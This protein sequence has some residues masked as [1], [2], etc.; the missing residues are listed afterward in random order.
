MEKNNFGVMLPL[1]IA[2]KFFEQDFHPKYLDT[3]YPRLIFKVSDH[4]ILNIFFNTIICY[5]TVCE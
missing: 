1:I 5:Q 3:I 2:V 4:K